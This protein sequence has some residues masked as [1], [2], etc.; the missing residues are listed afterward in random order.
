MRYL[1]PLLLF[2]TGCTIQ[3]AAAIKCDGKCSIDIDRGV[4]IKAPNPN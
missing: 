4:D 2:L 3:S 1:L